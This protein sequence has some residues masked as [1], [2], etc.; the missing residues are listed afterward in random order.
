MVNYHRHPMPSSED[1]WL[2]GQRLS[3]YKKAK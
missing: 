3:K 2:S 1:M